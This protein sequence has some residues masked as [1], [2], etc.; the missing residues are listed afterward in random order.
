MAAQAAAGAAFEKDIHHDP[1]QKP[2]KVCVLGGGNFGT[3][4]AFLAASKSHSVRWYCR[5]PKQAAAI[6]S[7]RR[8]PRYLSDIELPEGLHATADVAEALQGADY[9]VGDKLTLADISLVAYT[10]VAPEGGFDL[11]A[12]PALLKWIARVERDLGIKTAKTKKAA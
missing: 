4:M 3:A 5:D 6:S 8:N 10:R 1:K 2:Q 12:Y 11:A 7:T 9:L